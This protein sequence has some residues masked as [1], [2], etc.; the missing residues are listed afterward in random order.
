MQY[1][2]DTSA[3]LDGWIRWYPPDVGI[4]SVFWEK[5]ATFAQN[6]TILVSEEVLLDLKKHDDGAYKWS[7]DK[8]QV[9]KTD[10]AVQNAVREILHSHQ[11]LV[12]TRTGRSAS[13]P[14]VIAVA[15]LQS[16][17]VLTGEKPTG[18]VNKP[19]IP[20]VCNTLGIKSVNLVEFIREQ[21]W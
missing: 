8:F 17:A 18:N 7:K 9:H 14:F 19:N 16:C 20:D 11:R 1:S 6:G 4:F 10:E 13:D 5:I 12:D 2:I 15:K 21:H 3:I